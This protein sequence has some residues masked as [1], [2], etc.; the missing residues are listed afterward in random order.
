MTRLTAKSD[1]GGK[2]RKIATLDA[3]LDKRLLSYAAMAGAAG[4][5]LLAQTAQAEIVYT[6]AN[7]S[8]P[9]N[10]VI[11]VDLNH[12]GINDFFFFKSTFG[13]SRSPS[14]LSVDPVQSANR[15]LGN[16]LYASALPAGRAVG[17]GGKFQQDHGLMVAAGSVYP[18]PWQS[19][20]Q[21]KGTVDRYLGLMFYFHGEAHYG[22]AR[23]KVN[24][25]KYP[26][27]VTLLGYAYES[28]ANTAILTGATSGAEETSKNNLEAQP[29]VLSPAPASLGLL[30]QGFSALATWRMNDEVLAAR[31]P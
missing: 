26:V 20:G 19:R 3:A 31:L 29:S 4:V 14:S 7:I 24:A 1:G 16:K 30:A 11:S 21:W 6:A 27:T 10:S 5:G 9:A 25:T 12:D 28:E 15:I 22:W 17:P 23:L 18:G 2:K 8:I 13:F